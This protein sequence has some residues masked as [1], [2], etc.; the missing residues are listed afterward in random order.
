MPGLPLSWNKVD[1]EI[2]RYAS[3]DDAGVVCGET[4]DDPHGVNSESRC[5]WLAWSSRDADGER[6]RRIIRDDFGDAAVAQIDAALG[7]PNR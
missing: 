4:S 2:S 7:T 6:C 3:A 5:T 1:G